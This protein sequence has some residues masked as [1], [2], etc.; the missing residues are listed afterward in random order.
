MRAVFTSW[1]LVIGAGLAYMFLIVIL[2]R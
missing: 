2:G 1:L